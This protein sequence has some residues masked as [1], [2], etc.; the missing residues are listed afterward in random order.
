MAEFK[1]PYFHKEDLQARA[2]AFLMKNHPSRSIPV[3]VEHIIER[4]GVNIVPIPDLQL[5]C[6]VDAYTTGDLSTIY[7]EEFVYLHRPGRYRFTLAHEA[8]HIV[9]HA[10]LFRSMKFKSFR[11]WKAFV[12]SIPD[13]D[14]GYLEYHANEFA[15]HL[16]MP[17]RELL[18]EVEV[19]KGTV[20]EVI[21]EAP[22]DPD[23]FRDFVAACIAHRF[24]VSSPAATIR[25]NNE[26]V[27]FD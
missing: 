7:V 12:R 8:G 10:D 3:P 14:Y 19:C 5:S 27:R 11:D 16:L 23:A 15:G 18:Q 13:R 4:M 17:R 25:L 2:E 22:K 6:D 1:A 26:K 9:L 24:D 20:L 21:P